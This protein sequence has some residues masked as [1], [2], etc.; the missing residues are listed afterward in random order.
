MSNGYFSGL[1]PAVT[2][3]IAAAGFGGYPN[4]NCLQAMPSKDFQIFLSFCRL[5]GT[6]TFYHYTDYGYSACGQ[7]NS[8]QLYTSA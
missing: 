5:A 2:G 6:N 7:K 4:S 1:H 8:A 3:L